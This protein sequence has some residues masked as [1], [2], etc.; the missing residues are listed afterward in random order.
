MYAH[1]TFRLAG[2]YHCYVVLFSTILILFNLDC[3]D[4]FAADK[5]CDEFGRDW[6]SLR[7][8]CDFEGRVEEN[9]KTL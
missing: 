3:D 9:C 1:P 8:V 2:F 4:H 5:G 7:W 6:L